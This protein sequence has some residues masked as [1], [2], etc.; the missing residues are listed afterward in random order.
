MQKALEV[1]VQNQ[2]E[3]LNLVQGALVLNTT[4]EQI[5]KEY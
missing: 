4:L 5:L 1:M 3:P 2:K